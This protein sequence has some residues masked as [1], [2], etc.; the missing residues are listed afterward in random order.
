MNQNAE[1][2]KI[3]LP[4]IL[5]FAIGLMMLSFGMAITLAVEMECRPQHHFL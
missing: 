5:N 3:V 4:G 2:K 1:K